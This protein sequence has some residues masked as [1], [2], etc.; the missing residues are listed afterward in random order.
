MPGRKPKYEYWKYGIKNGE[1]SKILTIRLPKYAL[2]RIDNL[3]KRGVYSSRSEAIHDL[4]MKSNEDLQKEIAKLRE[5]LAFKNKE[6][7]ALRA[8]IKVLESENEELEQWKVKAKEL[9]KKL[10]ELQVELI[11]TKSDFDSLPSQE[12]FERGGEPKKDEELWSLVG[13]LLELRRKAERTWSEKELNEIE[14]EQRRIVE[15]VNAI[16]ER[17]GVDKVSFWK[18][19]NTKGLDEAKRLVGGE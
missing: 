4:I 9:E 17:R 18:V 7:E 10:E 11:K 15:D 3:I 8:R 19:L 1:K 2:D 13:R 5:Q 14:R 16:L 6:I 12:D